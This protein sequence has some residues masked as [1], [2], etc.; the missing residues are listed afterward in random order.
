MLGDFV[1]NRIDVALNPSGQSVS[2]RPHDSMA[3]GGLLRQSL[4]Q[5]IIEL[6]VQHHVSF[7]AFVLKAVKGEDLAKSSRPYR[8]CIN[9]FGPKDASK[10]VGEVLDNAGIYLQHPLSSDL[11]S[12]YINPHYLVRPGASHPTPSFEQ[13]LSIPTRPSLTLSSDE[14]LKSNVLQAMDDSAQGPSEYSYIAPSTWIR[15]PLKS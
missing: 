14:R 12:D 8:L 15:T 2:V 10:S 4:A 6:F 9:V 7:V 11:T 5:P 3:Y 13:Q 1:D